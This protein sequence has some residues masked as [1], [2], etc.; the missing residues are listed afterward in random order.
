MLKNTDF[1][2]INTKPYISSQKNEKTNKQK[3]HKH[4]RYLVLLVYLVKYFSESV[5]IIDSDPSRYYLL[6]L[7]HSLLIYP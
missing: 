4:N 5:F 7:L 2:E 1:Q 3:N 6:T